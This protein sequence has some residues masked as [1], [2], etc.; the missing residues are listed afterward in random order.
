MY[1]CVYVKYVLDYGL[2][3]L[4]DVTHVAKSEAKGTVITAMPH[5]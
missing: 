2:T 1:I 4:P 5:W 3:L